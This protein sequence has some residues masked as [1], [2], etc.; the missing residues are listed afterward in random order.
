MVIHFK[1]IF[2]KSI[3]SICILTGFKFYR[4]KPRLILSDNAIIKTRKIYFRI[5]DAHMSR[6]GSQPLVNTILALQRSTI[7]IIVT[8][9]RIM[10]LE[11]LINKKGMVLFLNPTIPRALYI[12]TF[13]INTVQRWLAINFVKPLF[14]IR[15]IRLL[16]TRNHWYSSGSLYL[17]AIDVLEN[18]LLQVDVQ[19]LFGILVKE[20]C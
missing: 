20:Y 8:P 2:F 17:L 14:I 12:Y 7:R 15:L 6:F 18:Y 16:R 13:I 11:E 4:R 5:Q 1:S 10:T 3:P 9:Y 19:I